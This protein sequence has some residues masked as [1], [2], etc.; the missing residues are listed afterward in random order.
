MSRFARDLSS[1]PEHPVT[2]NK[3]SYCSQHLWF[4]HKIPFV[5]RIRYQFSILYYEFVVLLFLGIFGP[6]DLPLMNIRN[7]LFKRSGASEKCCGKFLEALLQLLHTQ[8]CEML[9]VSAPLLKIRVLYVLWSKQ[10]Y[11]VSAMCQALCY[12]L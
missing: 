10:I 9:V 5:G 12:I 3:R 1:H 2:M 11:S 8:G 4:S 6:W 7:P